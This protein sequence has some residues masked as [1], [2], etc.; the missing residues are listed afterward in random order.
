M[1][2]CRRKERGRSA[3]PQEGKIAFFCEMML[4][5]VEFSFFACGEVFVAGEMTTSTCQ[6][7]LSS[8]APLMSVSLFMFTFPA[9]SGGKTRRGD[10]LPLTAPKRLCN[11]SP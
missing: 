3:R 10:S 9:F 8:F 6:R 11:R 1:A 4:R 7:M 5:F 2:R